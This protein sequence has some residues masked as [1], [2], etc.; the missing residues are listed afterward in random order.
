MVRKTLNHCTDYGRGRRRKIRSR[1]FPGFFTAADSD[2]HPAPEI[3]EA[4]IQYIQGGYFSYTPKRGFP[5]FK[6]AIA[7]ALA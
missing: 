1:R 7:K 5:E 4:M 2:F 6:E 3:A